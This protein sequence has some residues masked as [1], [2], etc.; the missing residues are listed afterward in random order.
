MSRT[1]IACLVL[2]LVAVAGVVAGL[3]LRGGHSDLRK[4]RRDA[5]DIVRSHRGKVLLLLLGREDC[6]GTK[7]ATAVLDGYAAAKPA[8]AAI[9]R[10]EVP[11]PGERAKPI[12]SWDHPFPYAVDENRA[13]AGE[14]GFF[15]YPTL[16]VFDRDG[17]LRFVGGCDPDRIDSMVAEILSERPGAEKKTYTLPMPAP[18]DV[19]PGFS[20]RTA[21]GEAVTLAELRGRRATLVFFA[22]TSCPFVVQELPNLKRIAGAFRERGVATVI[23][24]VGEE[25]EAV[26]AVFEKHAPGLPVIY[27]EEGEIS[28]AYGVDATPFYF[29]LDG[30]GRIARRR[31]FTAGAATG[32]VNALLGV[33]K[34]RPR[35]KP[36]EA[37]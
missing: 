36:T 18:G 2:G 9:V 14:L 27:D 7:R 17:V 28:E 31:S 21:S 34:E 22:R 23:V 16:Y 1:L 33:S 37:G 24:D 35:Y 5:T 4:D 26:R 29:L 13:T 6:P 32:S 30:D 10:L 3:F 20:G 19:A 11:L 8:G 25:A 12:R 15:Y